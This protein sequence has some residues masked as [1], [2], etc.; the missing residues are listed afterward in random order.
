MSEKTEIYANLARWREH[1][2]EERIAEKK[3]KFLFLF[4]LFYFAYGNVVLFQPALLVIR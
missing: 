2:E 1:E 4:L 3:D